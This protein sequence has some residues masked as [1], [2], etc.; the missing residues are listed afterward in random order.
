MGPCWSVCCVFGVQC[1]QEVFRKPSLLSHTYRPFVPASR[2]DEKFSLFIPYPLDDGTVFGGQNNTRLGQ[3]YQSIHYQC[4][5]FDACLVQSTI[6][7]MNEKIT[8]KIGEANAFAAVLKETYIANEA[9]LVE[10][11]GEHAQSVVSTADAQITALQAICEA[12]GTTDVLLPKVE[13]TA[14][15]ITD[16]G[17]AYVGDD[18]DDAAEVLEWFSFFVGGAIIHWELI[19]GAGEAMQSEELTAVAAEGVLYYEGL[20]A[21]L[22]VAASAIGKA[23]V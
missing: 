3:N 18:W 15:K 6:V 11:L 23:R 7:I 8:K 21:Q 13:K 2:P 4:V 14:V 12:A 10:L 9:V 22:K 16:M 19:A 17:E 20:L 1:S 5:I